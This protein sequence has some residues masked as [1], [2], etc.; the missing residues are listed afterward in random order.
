MLAG[1]FSVS[2]SIHMN[3]RRGTRR[4]AGG[5]VLK[6]LLLAV[7]YGLLYHGVTVLD[8]S[9]RGYS[10]THNFLS[11]LGVT[12]AFNYQRNVAGAVLFVVGAFIGV[13]ALA[14]LIVAT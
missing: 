10:F 9:T 13:L 11:D 5:G 3:I 12:V 6:V 14:S 4:T 7:A 1:P 2:T 8:E